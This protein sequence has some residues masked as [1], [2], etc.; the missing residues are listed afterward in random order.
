MKIHRMIILSMLLVVALALNVAIVS[1]QTEDT[2]GTPEQVML[3][4]VVKGFDADLGT[5]DVE[6]LLDSGELVI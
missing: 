4:G 1:A 5:L 2:T 6:V 3:V